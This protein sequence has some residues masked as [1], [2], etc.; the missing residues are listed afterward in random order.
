[1]LMNGSQT[2]L[3]VAA[4]AAGS[5]A[6]LP[7]AAVAQTAAPA[8]PTTLYEAFQQ[9]LAEAPPGMVEYDSATQLGDEGLEL[10]GLRIT[11]PEG[12]VIE[13]EHVRIDSLELSSITEDH[14]PAYMDLTVTGLHLPQSVLE[15]A[16]L[17]SLGLTEL[18]ADIRIDWNVDPDTMTLALNEASFELPGLG[19]LNVDFSFANVA[20]GA[21]DQPMMLMAASIASAHLSFDDDGLM[22]ALI[23]AIAAEDQITEEQVLQQFSEQM[24]QLRA[25]MGDEAGAPAIQGLDEIE[26]FVQD[27]EAPKG[28]LS[29]S[30]E[31]GQPVPLAVFADPNAASA[32]AETLNATITYGE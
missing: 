17:G 31:P 10:E 30:I 8:A 18:T 22:A 4:L 12:D 26:A 16:D 14:P 13:I 23:P 3:V 24:T 15:E 29:I 5:A 32:S 27:Y 1:M 28:P 25:M 9:S 2:A 21:M 20:P 6:A 7:A 11:T 19:T